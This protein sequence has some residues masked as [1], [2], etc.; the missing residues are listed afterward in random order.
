MTQDHLGSPRV[1]TNEIGAVTSRK[2]FAAFGEESIASQRSSSLGYQA[3]NIREDYTGYEK[4]AESGLEFAQTRYY[5]P[6]HGRYTSIDPLTASASI[7]NPQTFNRYSYVLNSP[8]NFVDPLGLL[9]VSTGANGQYNLGGTEAGGT[10]E[11]D[12]MKCRGVRYKWVPNEGVTPES[13]SNSAGSA[14]ATTAES[15]QQSQTTQTTSV[16]V[17]TP[18]GTFVVVIGWRPGAVGTDRVDKENGIVNYTSGKGVS[19]ALTVRDAGT[20]VDFRFWREYCRDFRR[21]GRVEEL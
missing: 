12:C 15:Q 8:Y 9:S 20:G 7:K 2:D 1:I 19:F 14:P 16:E 5:N 11:W 18:S 6:T 21:R 3:P 4:D 17:V 13:N 10:T